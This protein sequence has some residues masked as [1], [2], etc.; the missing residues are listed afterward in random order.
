MKNTLACVKK[1]QSNKDEDNSLKIYMRLW[2][3]QLNQSFLFYYSIQ[4]LFINS[5]QDFVWIQL[6]LFLQNLHLEFDWNV[7]ERD[8]RFVSKKKNEIGCFFIPFSYLMKNAENI[9][10]M[11]SLK[12]TVLVERRKDICLWY[13]HVNSYKEQKPE[14]KVEK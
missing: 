8:C 10:I 13:V 3:R 12:P 1:K 4:L 2:K 6:V 14:K 11:F 7:H 9:W 5:S